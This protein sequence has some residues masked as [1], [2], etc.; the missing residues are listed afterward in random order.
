[1][2]II[3]NDVSMIP[4]SFSNSKS[5]VLVSSLDTKNVTV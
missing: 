5:Q 4:S 2:A 1:M 3:L